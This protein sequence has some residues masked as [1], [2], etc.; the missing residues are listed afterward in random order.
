MI[1]W[2]DTFRA[3]MPRLEWS[4][5]T[6]SVTHPDD[7][8]WASPALIPWALSHCL[9]SLP[10]LSSWW[11]FKGL[12]EQPL[13]LRMIQTLPV[14]S[15]TLWSWFIDDWHHMTSSQALAPSIWWH[16]PAFGSLCLALLQQFLPLSFWYLPW[17]W[18]RKISSSYVNVAKKLCG[19]SS[20]ILV[21]PPPE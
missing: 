6:A 5:H 3:L 9:F 8:C 21:F 7:C 19:T 10:F 17:S 18:V 12:K 2:D 4:K 13:L 1:K 11:W 14:H 16:C 20:A 15:Q